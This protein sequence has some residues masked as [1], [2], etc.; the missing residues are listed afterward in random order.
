MNIDD[1]TTVNIS[2]TVISK[3]K[4]LQ[5]K[6]GTDNLDAALDKSLNIAY[7]V[8][9]KIEDPESKLLVVHKGKYQEVEGI[10]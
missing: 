5:E 8:A 4:A 1:A 6:L 10:N 2:D 7:F 3:L 9:G